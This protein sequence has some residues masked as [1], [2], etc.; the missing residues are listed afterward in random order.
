MYIKN[1]NKKKNNVEKVNDRKI[2]EIMEN[3]RNKRKHD[4]KKEMN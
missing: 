2:R 4:K 3:M 1:I